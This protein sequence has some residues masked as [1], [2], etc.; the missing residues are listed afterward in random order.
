MTRSSYKHFELSF[1]AGKTRE[2]PYFSFINREK[3]EQIL[4]RIAIQS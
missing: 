2:F 1:F 4:F 3:D